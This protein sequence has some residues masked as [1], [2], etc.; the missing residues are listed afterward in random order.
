MSK[1]KV[2]AGDAFLKARQENKNDWGGIQHRLEWVASHKG[3]DFINDSKATDTESVIYSLESIQKP[4]I[5]LC[6]NSEE[7]HNFW[8][9]EKLIKYKVWS[10]YAFGPHLNWNP[11]LDEWVDKYENHTCL[12]TAFLRA[13]K[14]ARPGTAVMMSPGNAS[15]DMYDN[16][17]ER[18]DAFKKVVQ[19][20]INY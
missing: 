5:W 20:W 10:I 4:V 12:E 6:G 9:M 16:Y 1:I 11:G 17:K 18:G 14:S 8:S 15:F 2:N 13:M 7:D 3:I 19:E